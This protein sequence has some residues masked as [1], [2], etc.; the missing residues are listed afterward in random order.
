VVDAP[1]HALTPGSTLVAELFKIDGNG[2]IIRIEALGTRVH[3]AAP[4]GWDGR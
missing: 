1:T 4:T 3:Y 2:E